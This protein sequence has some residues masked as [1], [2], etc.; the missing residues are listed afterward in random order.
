MK[1]KVSVNVLK[2]RAALFQEFHAYK[3]IKGK[4]SVIAVLRMA[5]CQGLHSHGNMKRKVSGIVSYYGLHCIHNPNELTGT[6][7]KVRP[8]ETKS[9]QKQGAS[10]E[11][12]TAT[13]QHECANSNPCRCWQ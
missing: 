1:G 12:V 7:E 2:R 3:N 4:V 5:L 13:E 6:A 9:S 8:D 10:R 11:N